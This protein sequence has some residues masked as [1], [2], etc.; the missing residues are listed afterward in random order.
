MSSTEGKV[1]AQ[2]QQWLAD[3]QLDLAVSKV[4]LAERTEEVERLTEENSTL[5]TRLKDF[6]QANEVS[7]LPTPPMGAPTF[8]DSDW[9]D[10]QQ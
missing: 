3:A 4:T 1:I 5:T 8:P 10:S 2:Y 7:M 6:N 9:T